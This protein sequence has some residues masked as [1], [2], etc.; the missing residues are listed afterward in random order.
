MDGTPQEVFNHAQ[1][2]LEMGLDIPEL[3]RIFLELKRLGLVVPSV[4]TMDQAV[5]AL[6]KLRGGNNYA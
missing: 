6:V 5:E 4:Y 3:T 2:L 1:E